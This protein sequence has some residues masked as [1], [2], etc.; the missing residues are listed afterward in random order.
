MSAAVTSPAPVLRR[1]AVMGSS[2]SLETTSCLMLRMISV[3]SSFT[4]GMV[5]NSWRTP[6]M[7]ML[8]TAAPGIDE[9]RLRRSAFPMV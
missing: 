8:V 9:R 7:R 3:T 5:L 4:P 1:Y 2:R 6:S